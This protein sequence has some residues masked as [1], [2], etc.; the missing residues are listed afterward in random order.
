MKVRL[1]FLYHQNSVPLNTKHSFPALKAIWWGY[2]YFSSILKEPQKTAYTWFVFN[3]KKQRVQS[4]LKKLPLNKA[5][6]TY[7]AHLKTVSGN[8][9]GNRSFIK[10]FHKLLSLKIPHV[11]RK[12]FAQL[13]EVHRKTLASLLHL[14]I[15]TT[16][17]LLHNHVCSLQDN[18]IRQRSS[19]FHSCSQQQ[20]LTLQSLK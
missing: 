3:N 13:V 17:V 14:S 11:C 1:S 2:V 20:A 4:L 18:Y 6:C 8:N 9:N 5:S 7:S 10:H 12:Q 19:S 15:A 16:N